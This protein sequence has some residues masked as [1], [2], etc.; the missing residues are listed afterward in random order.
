MQD[1]MNM[2]YLIR[3]RHTVIVALS[4]GDKENEPISIALALKDD[5]PKINLKNLEN[6]LR[7]SIRLVV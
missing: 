4:K 2:G 5:I 1:W 7:S 3:N 6:W